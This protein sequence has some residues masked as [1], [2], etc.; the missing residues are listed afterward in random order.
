MSLRLF[1]GL[2]HRPV[3]N[4]ADN[5]DGAAEDNRGCGKGHKPNGGGKLHADQEK[6]K[7]DQ[8]VALSVKSKKS[9][10]FRF[11]W[12]RPPII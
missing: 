11:A 8:V 4:R 3:P 5:D 2:E 9:S 1:G 10:L 12:V 7:Q 6:D